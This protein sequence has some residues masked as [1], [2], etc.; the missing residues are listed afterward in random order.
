[1]FEQLFGNPLLSE[2]ATSQDIEDASAE[3]GVTRR[4]VRQ[5]MGFDV[6][7]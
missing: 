2:C 7:P 5:L 6:T 3:L 4:R 1:M